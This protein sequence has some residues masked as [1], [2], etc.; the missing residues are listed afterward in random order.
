MTVIR[1][2]KTNYLDDRY[3]VTHL[4]TG[5]C[6]ACP[7]DRGPS[8]RQQAHSLESLR[9]AWD[10]IGAVLVEAWVKEKPFSRPW[11][12]WRFDQ[13]GAWV[14]PPVW[15]TTTQAA[16]YETELECLKRLGLLSDSERALL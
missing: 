15:A 4:K 10:A 8:G 6:L 3:T 16:E 13:P 9:T 2:T 1:K 14:R 12:F 5:Q 11:G 7:R